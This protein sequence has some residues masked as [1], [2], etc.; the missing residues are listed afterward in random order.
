MNRRTFIQGIGRALLASALPSV[1]PSAFA[2]DLIVGK[3][4]PS[5]VL[6]ALDGRTIDTRDLVGQVVVATFWATWCEPCREELPLLSR[7]QERHAADGL[8]VLGF[9]LDGGEQ[10]PAVS[11]FAQSLK[12]P[13]GLLGSPWVA[14]YG[15][16][17]RVPVSFV[18]DRRGQL[19]YDGWKDE[20]P[21]WSESSL[22]KIVTPLLK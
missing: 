6:H 11:K 2:N 22:Q 5:L 14:G 13:V 10:L 16:I 7:Y 21:V 1:V 8:Q 20:N 4:A 9:S 3:P 18:I 17:W 15:R 19:A 12:F